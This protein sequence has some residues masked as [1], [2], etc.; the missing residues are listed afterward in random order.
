MRN[1]TP[2]DV[3]KLLSQGKRV[4]G[5]DNDSDFWYIKELRLVT[6]SYKSLL[7]VEKHTGWVTE[8]SY[9]KTPAEMEADYPEW[10][11][12]YLITPGKSYLVRCENKWGSAIFSMDEGDGLGTIR[13]RN[14]DNQDNTPEL[15]K[16]HRERF[17]LT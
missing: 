17:D 13:V 9:G 2:K 1:Y 11:A 14:I 5:I 3:K 12:E 10:I 8:W 7:W 15:E 16:Y 6:N 4:I